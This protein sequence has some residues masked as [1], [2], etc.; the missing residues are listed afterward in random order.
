MYFKEKEDTNIDKELNKKKKISL[1]NINKKTLIII[2]IV[3][4]V[5]V[6]L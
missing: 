1:R 4:S 5:L 2:G 6:I 3:L